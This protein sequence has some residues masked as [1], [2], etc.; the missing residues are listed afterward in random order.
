MNRLNVIEEKLAELDYAK[1]PG[2]LI[3]GLKREQLVAMNSMVLHE[4]FFDGLGET[5]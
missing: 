4:L 1:V 2:F 5:K 3:N